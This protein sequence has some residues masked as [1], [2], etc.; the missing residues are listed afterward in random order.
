M[1]KTTFAKVL[2]SKQLKGKPLMQETAKNTGSASQ[3]AR[4]T[5]LLSMPAGSVKDLKIT[6]DSS[7]TSSEMVLQH[8]LIQKTSTPGT[9]FKGGSHQ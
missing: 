7:Q 1:L 3:R 5:G 9:F 6:T 2:L 8:M 4:A